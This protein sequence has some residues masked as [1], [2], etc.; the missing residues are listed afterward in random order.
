MKKLSDLI[1]TGVK[2]NEDFT[3][4]APLIDWARECINELE[5]KLRLLLRD[6]CQ[7]KGRNFERIYFSEYGEEIIRRD[8]IADIAD[9][10]YTQTSK[11][12]Y[13]KLINNECIRI[14][15]I[16]RFLKNNILE[17]EE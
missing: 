10:G 9:V 7:L 14:R 6:I 15:A 12:T 17:A 11:D 16:I 1:A 5:E 4:C 8:M 13:I 3:I 2:S